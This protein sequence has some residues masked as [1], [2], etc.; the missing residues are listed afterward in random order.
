M[1]LGTGCL[2]LIIVVCG[3][4]WGVSNG[5][6]SKDTL[7]KVSGFSIGGGLLGLALVPYWVIKLALSGNGNGV[8]P[9]A[10]EKTKAKKQ[11]VS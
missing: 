2:C 6:I 10:A 8:K 9:K 3:A 5:H 4:I 1:A 7:G 11:N